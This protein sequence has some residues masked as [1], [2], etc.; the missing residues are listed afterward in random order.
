MSVLHVNGVELY[1]E[2]HG[3]GEVLLFIHGLGSST[4][5]WQN[6]VDFFA[7]HYKAILVDVRGHGKSD[8]PSGPYSIPLFANDLA[9]FL[10]SL[11]LAPV[12]V[13]GISMGGMIAFQLAINRPDLVK[14]LVVVNASP[15]FVARSFKERVKIWQRFVIVRLLG[16]RKVGEV[17]SDRLFPKPE[18]A[19]LREIFVE[20]WAE[21]D[22][23]A[24]GDAM[25]AIVGWSVVDKL[26][27][28]H[29][30]TLILASDED[31]TPVA[32]KRAYVAK[33]T[34]GKL[35]IIQDARHALPAERPLEF[36]AALNTFLLESP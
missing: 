24:Y 27:N 26:E 7:Q 1:Y 3:Q 33:L 32:E 34:R 21:N 16:M 8:K 28:I 23:R 35:V 15:E 20:R 30:P 10:E 12:H 22:S 9:G 25:R 14:S 5:D 11:K 2:I 13:I 18:H 4:R 6:Q 29:C 31:Y 19:E 36:N 17:L